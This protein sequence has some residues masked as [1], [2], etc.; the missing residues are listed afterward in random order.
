MSFEKKP[1]E[2]AHALFHNGLK[3]MG[4]NESKISGGVWKNVKLV[5]LWAEH[6]RLNSP[7]KVKDLQEKAGISNLMLLV[8]PD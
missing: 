5:P 3:A 8:G 6:W 4:G 2:K 7:V 1:L